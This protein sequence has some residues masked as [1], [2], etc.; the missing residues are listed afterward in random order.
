MNLPLAAICAVAVLLRV[1]RIGEPALPDE[2]ICIALAREVQGP[3][4]S[5]PV[6]GG[7]HPFLGTYL[8]ALSGRL[9]GDSVVGYRL[10]G[11]LV[12]GFTP[13]LVFHAVRTA[14]TPRVALV[15]AALL[16]INPLHIGLSA[17][18]FEIVYQ[19][20]FVGLAWLA[21]TGLGASYARAM[22]TAFW[23]GCAFLCS[24]SSLVIALGF[25]LALVAHALAQRTR[26]PWRAYAIGLGVFL[27]VIVPDLLYNLT[28]S[29]NSLG[30]T[31]YADHLG[32]VGIFEVTTQGAG[33]FLRD[34]FNWISPHSTWWWD[35]RCEY[36]GPT[37][38]AGLLLLAGLCRGIL[39][40]R[41]RSM[42][43]AIMPVVLLLAIPSFLVPVPGTSLEPPSWTWPA[44]TLP[45]LMLPTA[46]LIERAFSRSRIL[47]GALVALALSGLWVHSPTGLSCR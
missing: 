7:D 36:P 46:T 14:A 10:L 17:M 16:A 34:V 26:I 39:E 9:F 44:P 19:T 20:A 33:F 13:A 15:G 4:S 29:R 1:L 8:L 28:S 2:E 42:T 38:P 41:S 37:M 47:G 24:E 27:C 5:W 32:R 45:L 25:A 12:G 30:F 23:L 11:T 22:R 40:G 3:L 43:T 18:A 31:N 21:V 6:H 35:Y